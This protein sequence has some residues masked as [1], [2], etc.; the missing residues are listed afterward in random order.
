[1]S[2]KIQIT[3]HNPVMVVSDRFGYPPEDASRFR[4]FQ[5]NILGRQLAPQDTPTKYVEVFR[6]AFE[7]AGKSSTLGSQEKSAAKFNESRI[8]Q[9]FDSFVKSDV[10]V[11]KA[12]NST[13]SLVEFART[14]VNIVDEGEEPLTASS[15]TNDYQRFA[16]AQGRLSDIVSENENPLLPRS[17][18]LISNLIEKY[19][20]KSNITVLPEPTSE[21]IRHQSE[22]LF[23]L[24]SRGLEAA[25]G[26]DEPE[27]TTDMLIT[28][29]PDY[30]GVNIELD[31]GEHSAARGLEAAYDDDEPEYTTDTLI[32]VNPDYEEE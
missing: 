23:Y 19:K 11:V 18:P 25:Y 15:V 10:F 32:E 21:E 8:L 22:S 29:N 6:R 2:R 26:D 16:A 14:L 1:M 27:Y 7:N 5:F 3:Q 9:S 28:V 17:M 24:G 30:E 12:S 13:E 4:L 31:S 20:E